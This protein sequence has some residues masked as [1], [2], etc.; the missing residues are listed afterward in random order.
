MRGTRCSAHTVCHET[1]VS[2][3]RTHIH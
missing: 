2:A 1:V 3:F